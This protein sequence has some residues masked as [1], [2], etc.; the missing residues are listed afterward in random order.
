M[1][2]GASNV[3]VLIIGLE[4]VRTRG[5]MNGAAGDQVQGTHDPALALVH[6]RVAA[7]TSL[8]VLHAAHVAGHGTIHS[9]GPVRA[10]IRVVVIL[11]RI[12]TSA[13][14]LGLVPDLRAARSEK[15]ECDTRKGSAF[16]QKA[17]WASVASPRDDGIRPPL[18]S[19][20]FW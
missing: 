20:G 8:E 16:F 19:V 18:L 3:E 14:D 2:M 11:K 6:T 15:T 13:R 12:I 1:T 5:V 10:V 4:N 9:Q 17:S 7:C